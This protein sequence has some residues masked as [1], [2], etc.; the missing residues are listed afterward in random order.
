MH[1]FQAFFAWCFECPKDLFLIHSSSTPFC[2]KYHSCFHNDCNLLS[3]RRI[4]NTRHLRLSM[5]CL[6]GVEP[7][8]LPIRT[9]KGVKTVSLPDSL[10]LTVQSLAVSSWNQLA[11]PQETLSTWLHL[12]P[13]WSPLSE[14][15]DHQ[16]SYSSLLPN[17]FIWILVLVFQTLDSF[18][19][20]PSLGLS[21][22]WLFQMKLICCISSVGDFFCSR[23][24]L[25]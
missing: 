9:N 12:V 5:T 13:S 4:P 11:C 17:Q 7:W 21:N 14:I 24:R 22:P 19:L 25:S 2:C 20:D 10:W 8:H 3:T 16:S 6:S 23:S 18:H 15:P 1:P